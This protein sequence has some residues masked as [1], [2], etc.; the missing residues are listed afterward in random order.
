V[1][2]PSGADARMPVRFL[3]RDQERQFERLGDHHPA[4]LPRCHLGEDEVVVF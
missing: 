3:L 1:Q 2:P 4:D